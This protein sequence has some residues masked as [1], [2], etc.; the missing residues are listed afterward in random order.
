MIMKKRISVIG[1]WTLAG[2]GAVAFFLPWV[3]PVA[4]AKQTSAL[5]VAHLLRQGEDSF[6]DSWIGMRKDEWQIVLQRPTVGLS[7][8]QLLLLESDK[9]IA[10]EE[11]QSWLDSVFGDGRALGRVFNVVP[12][13]M[14]LLTAAAMSPRK[15]SR[16][17]FM[18]GGVLLLAFYLWG[19]WRLD[20]TYTQ[21]IL[22]E[23]EIAYGLWITLY[24]TL[25][26][27]ILATLRFFSPK[28]KW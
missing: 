5:D 9:D 10:A 15:P 19:R 26:L 1:A 7:G 2:I 22:A 25:A 16:Q 21:R 11:A 24:T 8:F 17:I 3:R 27:A 18:I 12:L 13:I 28:G 4:A 6:F 23:M 14:V 20:V